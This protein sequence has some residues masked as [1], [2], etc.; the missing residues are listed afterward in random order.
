MI[1]TLMIMMVIFSL[2]LLA[3][4]IVIWKTSPVFN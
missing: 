4:G 2:G 1:A 3:S